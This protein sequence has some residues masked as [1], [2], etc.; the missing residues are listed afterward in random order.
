MDAAN[1][2]STPPSSEEDNSE[3]SDEGSPY[4]L[5]DI[6]YIDTYLPNLYAGFKY[7]TL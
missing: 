1:I 6:I 3:S 4:Y 2:L 7:S 5:L